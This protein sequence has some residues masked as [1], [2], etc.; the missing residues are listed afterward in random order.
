M[1]TTDKFLI[2]STVIFLAALYL[3]IFQSSEGKT[4]RFDFFGTTEQDKSN[5]TFPEPEEVARQYFE[6]WD[7]KDYATMYSSLSD[8]FRKINPNA[9]SLDIFRN[10]II[11]QR[12]ESLKVIEI[13]KISSTSAVAR[14]G[15]SIE[16][17][18]AD[19]S[20]K[21]SSGIFS[22][23]M[24]DGDIIPGWKITSAFG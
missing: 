6:A 10:F 9:T 23:E 17:A 18:F 19:G 15:Y 13:K 21:N 3:I 24:K 5:Y 14:I 7:R 2:A 8:S 16:I 12:V 11:S 4:P 22:V 20:K 1:D